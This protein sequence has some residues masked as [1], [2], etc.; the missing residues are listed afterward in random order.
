[1]TFDPERAERE[2][3]YI[4]PVSYNQYMEMYGGTYSEFSLRSLAYMVQQR[5]ATQSF[6]DPKWEIDLATCDPYSGKEEPS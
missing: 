4:P 2:V 6:V 5:R 3:D 1:M